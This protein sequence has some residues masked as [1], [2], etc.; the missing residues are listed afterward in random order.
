MVGLITSDEL[1]AL[2]EPYR[3]RLLEGLRAGQSPNWR[4]DQRTEDLWVLGQYLN[5]RFSHLPDERRR[6]LGHAF[7]RMV[8]S[9]ED[10]WTVAAQVL[11]VGLQGLD[12]GVYSAQYWTARNHGKWDR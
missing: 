6:E 8:R 2:L 3:D 12:V 9:A 5:E 7:H 11:L 10:V 4:C 1:K